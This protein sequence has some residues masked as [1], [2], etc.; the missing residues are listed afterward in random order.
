MNK[1]DKLQ[2][3]NDSSKENKGQPD[4]IGI[5]PPNKITLADIDAVHS[6]TKENVSET[7][8]GESE[9][10]IIRPLMKRSRNLLHCLSQTIA[11]MRCS[12]ELSQVTKMMPTGF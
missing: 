2:N 4:D 8:N 5:D 11:G 9:A 7:L 12:F 10:P 3:K 6:T 1:K